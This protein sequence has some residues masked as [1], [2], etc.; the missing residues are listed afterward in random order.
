[1]AYNFWNHDASPVVPRSAVGG[2]GA[3]WLLAAIVTA[4]GIWSLHHRPAVWPADAEDAG[5]PAP[6]LESRINPNEADWP[7]LCR[8][9]GIGPAR[10][11][12]IVA[13]RQQY[14]QTHGPTA[15]PFARPE[16]LAVVEGIGPKTIA[17]FKSFL[18]FK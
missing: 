16:D 17:D 1:M 2:W 8:L 10:A 3:C 18:V 7:S 15:N 14:R 5:P 12:A 11:Q 4:A 6:V 13:Y 9:P